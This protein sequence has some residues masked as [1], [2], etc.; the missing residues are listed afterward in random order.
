[1]AW[2]DERLA[3]GHPEFVLDTQS[4]NNLTLELTQRTQSV[5]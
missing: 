5:N 4:H 1:M 2:T 3:H